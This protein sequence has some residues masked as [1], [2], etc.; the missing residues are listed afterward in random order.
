MKGEEGIEGLYREDSRVLVELYQDKRVFLGK[1]KS[2][3]ISRAIQC[4]N[5]TCRCMY[6]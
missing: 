4:M 5:F 6:G 3:Y 1:Y 2:E